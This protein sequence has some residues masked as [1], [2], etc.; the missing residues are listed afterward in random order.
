MGLETATFIDQ[1]VSANPVHTDSLSQA[2]S[3]IRLLKSVLQNQFPN[4]TG[5]A[6]NSTNAAID[7]AVAATL[8]TALLQFLA[9]TAAAPGLASASDPTTGIYAPAV[10]ELGFATAGVEALE[11]D[12]DQSVNA[13]A[14]V[15]AVGNATIGGTLAVTGALSG[16]TGQ[17]A[18]IGEPRL[19]LS[20]TLPA[21]NVI[22]LNGQAISRTANPILFEL[23]GVKFGGGDGSTTFNVPNFQ[24]VVPIGIQGMGGAKDPGLVPN[25]TFTSTGTIVGQATHTLTQAELPLYELSS[26]GLT[27]AGATIPLSALGLTQE[28]TEVPS[29]AGASF[30]VAPNQFTYTPSGTIG[31]GV[32]SG[33]SNAAHNIVQPSIAVG[34][35]TLAG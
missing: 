21:G 22:W 6:L 34:W 7:A 16:G 4:F 15:T 29:G 17:L 14:N 27:F 19:W 3:H 35:I 31:G 8:G 12:K 25:Q 28:N 32:S 23:W 33:G 9:G 18:F 20:D 26:A 11:I 13:K 24:D 2:D 5:A 1:L 30:G 10:G